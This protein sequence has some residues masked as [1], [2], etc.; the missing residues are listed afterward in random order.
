[1]ASWVE[2]LGRADMEPEHLAAARKFLGGAVLVGPIAVTPNDGG[3]SFEG[4]SRLDGR[5]LGFLAEGVTP[6]WCASVT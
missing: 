4:R 3:W 5:L 6:W 2:L 1:M